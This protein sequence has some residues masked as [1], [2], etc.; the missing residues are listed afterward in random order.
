ML[1]LALEV[2]SEAIKV[3][4]SLNVDFKFFPVLIINILEDVICL[5]IEFDSLELTEKALRMC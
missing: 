1:W 5:F 4:L 3:M 2:A